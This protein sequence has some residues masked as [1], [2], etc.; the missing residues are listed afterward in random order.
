MGLLSQE[1]IDQYHQDGVVF[2]RGF[3]TP[4]EV[5]SVNDAMNRYVAEVVP[6]LPEAERVYE[7]DTLHLRNLFHMDVHDDFFSNFG[8]Q[9][10]LIDLVEEL[11]GWR[12]ELH[13]VESFMKPAQCG[14]EVPMHQ[15]EP[16]LGLI[17][18]QFAT[19]WFPLD[20][21]D[22]GN[23]TLRFILGSHKWGAIPHE[24]GTVPGSPF[25]TSNADA[26][27]NMPNVPAILEP[28]DLALFPCRLLHY[29]L[30]NR[31]MR[32]RRI[33]G[34]GMRGPDAGLKMSEDDRTR[35]VNSMRLDELG[36]RT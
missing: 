20:P 4:A 33:V 23:G 25:I 9:E 26:L 24:T 21:V 10:K 29:S 3:L 27:K 18:P 36:Q 1:E 28:G 35:I 16:F 13:Y 30:P 17:H 32:R 22:E 12:Y 34:V 2:V 19:A 8:T 31:S 5:Q 15:D 7:G 14:S 11:E 6:R